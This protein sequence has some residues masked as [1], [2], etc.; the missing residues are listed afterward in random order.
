MIGIFDSGLGGLTALSELR[1]RR[2]DLDILYYADTANLPYGSRSPAALCRLAKRAFGFLASMG[3]DAILV[4]CGTV[5]SVVLPTM[6]ESPVPLFGVV[7]PACR[8]AY[9]LSPG[10]RIGVL[11]TEATIHSRAYETYLQTLGSVTL[12]SVACPLFVPLVE[13]GFVAPKDPV[14]QVVC[15]AS[16]A[17]LP[18]DVDC[19][20]LGCTHFSL[21]APH[22]QR[23][24]PH[25]VLIGAGE[26]AAADLCMSHPKVGRGETHFYVTDDP[27]S[28]QNKATVHLGYAPHVT[29]I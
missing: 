5:S 13:N 9:H 20:I 15:E 17:P 23:I 12:S 27:L 19:L 14:P 24:Y 16:L 6:Q 7:E 1:M 29:K 22:I 2:R 4:A 10:H 3:V 11:A 25:A 8:L 21:L 18:R 28:F 26:A